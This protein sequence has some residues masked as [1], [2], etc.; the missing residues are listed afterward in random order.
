M[1]KGENIT[2]LSIKD[3]G[4]GINKDKLEKIFE[5]FY[6]TKQNGDGFGLYMVRLIIE[7][8]MDGKIDAIYNQDGAKFLICL[9][10]GENEGITT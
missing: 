6:S 9:K 1:F 5:P 7:D 3:N 8:K 2:C 4:I 10:E